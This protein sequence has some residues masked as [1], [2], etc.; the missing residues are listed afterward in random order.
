MTQETGGREHAEC[1]ASGCGS[2]RRFGTVATESSSAGITDAQRGRD[3]RH[4]ARLEY[5][6]VGWNVLEGIVAIAAARASDSV[7]LLAFGID[8]FVECASGL[9][10]LWRLNAERA[11][12]LTKSHIEG[13]ERR[14]HKLVAFSLFL[15]AAYV[16]FD[17]TAQLWTRERPLFSAVGV[18]LTVV[19]I[20]VMSIL[21]RAK[22]RL[23][24]RLGSRALEADAFQTTACWWL[25]IAAL[26][27][28]GLNGAFS[29]WWADPLAACVIAVLVAKEGLEAWRGEHDCC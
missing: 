22:R 8:S 21:A 26:I 1:T 9:V 24:I 14:A 12:Q 13:L 23:A 4:A 27:G 5:F 2:E 29:W 18:S 28:V 16:A 25:S 3:L 10:M 6:T 17:A 11:G 15:L 19:S 20:C 7:A